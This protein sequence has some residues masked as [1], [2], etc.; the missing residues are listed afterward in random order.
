ML[1]YISKTNS[2][3]VIIDQYVAALRRATDVYILPVSVYDFLLYRVSTFTF[4]MAFS[5]ANPSLVKE[6]LL[7]RK[8]YILKR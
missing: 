2:I 1:S 6:Y 5:R 3:I 8:T 7:E 4:S